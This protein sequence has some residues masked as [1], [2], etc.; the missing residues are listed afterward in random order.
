MSN[1]HTA[2][3]MLVA[4]LLVVFAVGGGTAAAAD[5]VTATATLDG[6]PLLGANASDPIRL[7][8]SEVAQIT[9]EITNGTGESIS[10][11]R[12]DLTGHVLGLN[13]F[14]YSTAVEMTIAAGKTEKLTYRLDAAG[15]D[16]Q[17]TGLIGADL[18]IIGSDGEPVAEVPTVVDVRGSL[19]SVYG[20]FG[21]ILAV[22][23]ALALADAA[24]TVARH[25]LSPNRWQRGLR[26]LAPGIGIGLMI[27]FTA[28]VAR[29]WVP[30][31][32]LWLALAGSTA[33]IFFLA[34]YFSP[35]PDQ[36]DGL[37]LDAADLAAARE[38]DA[39]GYREPAAAR[40]VHALSGKPTRGS[41]SDAMRGGMPAQGFGMAAESVTGAAVF[42]APG[43]AGP[44]ARSFATPPGGGARRPAA[45]AGDAPT[46]VF[47]HEFGA[48]RPPGQGGPPRRP[49]APSPF[50]PAVRAND[51][52][53]GGGSR[54]P[55]GPG[56]HD[57][58]DEDTVAIPPPANSGRSDVAAVGAPNPH[59]QRPPRER[60][61]RTPGGTLH[62][63]GG[64]LADATRT[65]TAKTTTANAARGRSPHVRPVPGASRGEDAVTREGPSGSGS[66]GEA[67]DL[68][69]PVT[70][71][72]SAT[73]ANTGR[74]RSPQVR[75]VPGASRGDDAVTIG[76]EG[77]NGSG[78]RGEASDLDGPASAAGSATT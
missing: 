60:E 70:A 62:D 21:I 37:D 72:G 64:T 9:V 33:T 30:A 5:G 50:G 63:L 14:S 73:T 74:G 52:A 76:R 46:T 31:T 78:S 69:G 1:R 35:T 10:V 4:A 6:E 25:R 23:T 59:G 11:R 24:L 53:A 20:L 77:P 38:L 43:A 57:P 39:H 68:D 75:P 42:G 3:G 28:S 41:G 66:R 67:S 47:G 61:Q 7:D 26:L 29:W 27:G 13:F 45:D 58:A 32:G 65:D 22:L 2:F 44:G 55:P 49:G 12:A 16:G 40:D 56:W 36:G 17:A 54:R 18:T 51:E 34:G 15:L 71:A 19:F 8:P 48:G